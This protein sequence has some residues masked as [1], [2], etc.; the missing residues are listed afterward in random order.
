[1]KY[2]TKNQY[3]EDVIVD[4]D[5][6]L[7]DWQKDSYTALNEAQLAYVESNPEA[8]ATTVKYCEDKP[9][10]VIDTTTEEF[11]VEQYKSFVREN[12]SQLSLMISRE[13]VSDYQFLNAQ[14]SLLLE[15]GKG[16]YSHEEAN[17]I[18]LEY[19]EIGTTCRNMYYG[20][21]ADLEKLEDQ[22][23]IDALVE[24]INAEYLAL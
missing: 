9:T 5:F 21:V 6:E 18:I 2:F 13:K 22:E 20:F 16:I 19:N 8:S 4:L 3:N 10:E 7:P 24:K 11:N 15:D 23:S 1:M 17:K 12:I 14:A